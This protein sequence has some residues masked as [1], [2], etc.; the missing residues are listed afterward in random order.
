M[1]AA[2]GELSAADLGGALG[3]RVKRSRETLE[4]IGAHA[5]RDAGLTLYTL[6]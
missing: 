6:V 3:W 2:A 1:L 4:R 5:H